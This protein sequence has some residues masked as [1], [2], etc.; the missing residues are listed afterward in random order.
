[1]KYIQR[2]GFIAIDGSSLTVGETETRSDD[3]FFWL[4]SFPRHCA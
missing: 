4:V 2:K 1:M 3:G